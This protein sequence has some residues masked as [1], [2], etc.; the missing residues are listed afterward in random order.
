MQLI[1]D[2][3]MHETKHYRTE[4]RSKQAKKLHYKNQ[5]SIMRK[6]VINLTK[7]RKHQ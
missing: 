1:I 6:Y 3:Q 5:R 7:E 2:L 4:R